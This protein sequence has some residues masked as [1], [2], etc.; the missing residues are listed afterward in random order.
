ML[1]YIRISGFTPIVL[2]LKESDLRPQ[3]CVEIVNEY[4]SKLYDGKPP[5]P[6]RPHKIITFANNDKLLV[7]NREETF[8]SKFTLPIQQMIPIY[9]EPPAC[10]ESIN[11]VKSPMPKLYPYNVPKYVSL[12]RL[13]L[14][15]TDEKRSEPFLSSVF[16]WCYRGFVKP[17]IILQKLIERFDV[18]LLQSSTPENGIPP[19]SPS[20]AFSSTVASSPSSLTSPSNN[21]PP[22][23][24]F[25]MLDYQPSLDEMHYNIDVRS[26][27]QLS[28]AKLLLDWVEKYYFDFDDK[29]VRQLSNFCTSRMMESVA[30]FIAKKILQAMKTSSRLPH[31]EQQQV[32]EKKMQQMATQEVFPVNVDS[33]PES[34]KSGQ[35]STPK[36]INTTM[37]SKQISLLK[38]E[39]KE[40]A[41]TLTLLDHS[42]YNKIKFT[43][44]LG[45]SWNKDK[46]RFMA[47]NI[48]NVTTLFNKISNYCVHQI[49][50]EPNIMSRKKI[51]E[52]LFKTCE[53]L[54][55]MNSFNMVMAIY[56]S[57]VSSSV[58][59]LT[60]TWGMLD[61]KCT[62]QYED[63]CKFVSTDNN[64]RILRDAMDKAFADGEATTP[65]LG[66]YLR[67]LVFTDDGNPTL[68]DGK[69]NFF[70][71]INQYAIM[72]N[73]LRFQG[74]EYTFVMKEELQM[75]IES[76]KPKSE[77][78][79]YSM[80]LKT[81]PRK[82]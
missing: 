52:N 37:D 22:W 67:D 72:F 16:W 23:S 13:I 17:K 77:D 62:K 43:E 10:I 11:Y 19:S 66:I 36:N 7:F 80:S 60:D 39:P 45:Q 18:P 6:L 21:A 8:N 53:I 12:N 56:S 82:Q 49:V 48:I 42:I 24:P 51:L 76:Y 46:K 69:L 5:S 73:I 29:M 14:L 26:N 33:S 64:Q 74:R 61:E 2:N 50:S 47:P 59:R 75:A 31:W 58:S 40:I 41:E 63:I 4:Y 25:A 35:P 28:V 1:L 3:H 9:D 30:S 81:Q 55:E 20:S 78:E 27:I 15:L 70:K 65:Y 68:I 38:M 71:A 79:L 44:M 57:F 54:R 34:K 32:E